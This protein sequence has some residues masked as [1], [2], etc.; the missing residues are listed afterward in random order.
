[1][2][3]LTIHREAVS[4]L[5]KLKLCFPESLFLH[6]FRVEWAKGEICKRLGRQHKAGSSVL[7]AIAAPVQHC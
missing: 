6:S 2:Y 7:A 1:M 3:I 5:A 4:M